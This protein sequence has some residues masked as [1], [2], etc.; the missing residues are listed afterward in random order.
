RDSADVTGIG[1]NITDEDIDNA[2]DEAPPRLSDVHA[3]FVTTNSS[4]ISNSPTKD[5]AGSRADNQ[6]PLRWF[7][8]FGIGNYGGTG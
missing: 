1:G 8:R 3:A 4:P 7:Q 5:S 2:E 6:Q